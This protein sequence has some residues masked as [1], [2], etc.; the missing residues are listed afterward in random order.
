MLVIRFHNKNKFDKSIS[1]S[2]PEKKDKTTTNPLL[3]N[4]TISSSFHISEHSSKVVVF[5]LEPIPSD[6]E[7]YLIIEVYIITEVIEGSYML[8]K[9]LKITKIGLEGSLRKAN[10]GVTYFGQCPNVI[11]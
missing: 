7:P 5:G 9:K 4:N 8:N 10:D 11:L 6:K 2:T 3:I 1:P